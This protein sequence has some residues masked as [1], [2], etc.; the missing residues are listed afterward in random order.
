M[1]EDLEPAQWSAEGMMKAFYAATMMSALGQ[2][3]PWWAAFL[4]PAIIMLP[5]VIMIWGLPAPDRQVRPS[6]DLLKSMMDMH[7]AREGKC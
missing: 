2:P 6:L 5:T 4:R 7:G 3:G 1:G